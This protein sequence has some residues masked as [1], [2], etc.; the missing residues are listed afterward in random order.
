MKYKKVIN[1]LS[2]ELDIPEEVIKTAY[3]SYWEFIK[4]TI[5]NLPLKECI[6]QEEINKLRVNFNIP[7]IGK[8]YC[9]L[10]R[11]VRIK[12]NFNSK[13]NGNKNN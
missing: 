6:S 1:Q 13:R 10:N 7:S 2:K 3:N 4:E 11:V 12:N 9:D 8:L 5:Q